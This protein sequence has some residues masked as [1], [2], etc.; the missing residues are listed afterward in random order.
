MTFQ[1]QDLFLVIT[2]TNPAMFCYEKITSDSSSTQ[3]LLSVTYL[4]L[5]YDLAP[6]PTVSVHCLL[7]D[8]SFLDHHPSRDPKH[9]SGCEFNRLA[10]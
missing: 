7:V 3:A 4:G 1:R 9:S 10:F 8:S 6:L 2:A 5:K